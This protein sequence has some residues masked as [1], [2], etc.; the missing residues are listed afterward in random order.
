M[1]RAH[2]HCPVCGEM[3]MSGINCCEHEQ[4]RQLDLELILLE[5]EIDSLR[6]DIAILELESHLMRARNERLQDENERL[7]RKLAGPCSSH[8]YE[9]GDK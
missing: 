1:S 3:T 7:M 2:Y 5:Q 6:A 4:P 8:A 9:E